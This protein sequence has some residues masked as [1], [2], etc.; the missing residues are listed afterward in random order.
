MKKLKIVFPVIVFSLVIWT[1]DNNNSNK[2][3]GF[4]HAVTSIVVDKNNTKW[5][6]TEDGLYQNAGNGYESVNISV[7]GKIR[8]LFYEENSNTLWIGTDAGLDKATVNG[9]TLTDEVISYDNLSYSTILSAYSD[10]ASRKWFGTGKG[11]SLDDN[12][13]WKNDSF[14]VNILKNIFPMKLEGLPVNSIASWDGDYYFATS[15]GSLYRATGFNDTLDAFSGETQWG[16]PYNGQNITDTMFVVFVDSKGNQWMGGKNG[17]QVHTGHHPKDLSALTYYNSELAGSR[18]HAIAEGPDGRI[19]VGTEKG[20][21]VYDGNSW[22]T[23]TDKLPDLF[24][25]SI[26]FDKD[27]TAWIGTKKGIVNI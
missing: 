7:T 20:L 13:K 22:T 24:V 5:I 23:I 11:I 25:T 17:I 9:T 15:G 18:V 4:D 27:G 21:S 16:S 19:W 1:C 26:A 8:S 6:G 3:S 14:R 2:I 10:S 12:G